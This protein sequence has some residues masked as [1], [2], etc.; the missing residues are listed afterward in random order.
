MSAPD[1]FTA[2]SAGTGHSALRELVAQERAGKAFR[3]EA[4][5]ALRDASPLLERTLRENW[6]TGQG[7]RL[8]QIL[9]SLYNGSG[10]LPLGYSL[11]GFDTDL[12]RAI[13]AAIN[14]RLALGAD[15]EDTIKHLLEK[16]GE[17]GRFAEAMD[18]TPEPH[19]VIYPPS[20]VSP[21]SFRDLA[22]SIEAR[23]EFQR[24]P[25]GA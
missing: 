20:S 19:V 8:R 6:D 1:D 21:D 11:S 2:S 4:R 25:C 3:E 22:A 12:A 9:W 10:L 13:G 14:G 18:Q 17:F 16:A 15:V 7:T 5:T 23:A 24:S